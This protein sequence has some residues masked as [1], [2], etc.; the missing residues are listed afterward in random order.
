MQLNE[1]EKLQI[2]TDVTE[3]V[4]FLHNLSQVITVL[5]QIFFENE[6]S[7][8]FFFFGMGKNIIKVGIYAYQ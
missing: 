6:I 3:A 8:F 7:T 1:M 5:A 4:S 2:V